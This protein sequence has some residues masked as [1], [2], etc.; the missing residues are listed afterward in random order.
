MPL[1]CWLLALGGLHLAF[2]ISGRDLDQVLL[3]IVGMLGGMSLLLM[4]RLPQGL[5]V[6]QLGDRTLHAR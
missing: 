3:P 2:V 1:V 5:V 4:E 6:Q